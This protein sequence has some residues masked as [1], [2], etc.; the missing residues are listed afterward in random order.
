MLKKCEV[1]PFVKP[2]MP[3]EFCSLVLKGLHRTKVERGN[4]AE[5]RGLLLLFYI[6]EDVKSVCK[7]MNE[8]ATIV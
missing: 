7:I 4:S 5:P 8:N 2:N 6:L 1:Y 3:I